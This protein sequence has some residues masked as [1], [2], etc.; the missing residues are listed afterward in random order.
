MTTILT[1]TP[2][3]KLIESELLHSKL[4]GYIIKD[5]SYVSGVGLFSNALGLTFG[6][7]K[8][9]TCHAIE[10]LD[11]LVVNNVEFPLLDVNDVEKIKGIKTIIVDKKLQVGNMDAIIE[12]ARTQLNLEEL[13]FTSESKEPTAL[14]LAFQL[15]DVE[16]EHKAVK[17]QSEFGVVRAMPS[18][19]VKKA[20][21]RPVLK[22]TAPCTELDVSLIGKN[23]TRE[24]VKLLPS[25]KPFYII[26]DRDRKVVGV[27]GISLACALL[28]PRY[29]Y[30]ELEGKFKRYSM[31]E[32]SQV[33]G[34]IPMENLHEFVYSVMFAV[35]SNGRFTARVEAVLTNIT[36]NFVYYSKMNVDNTEI[37]VT[38]IT[39]MDDA[40]KEFMALKDPAND[41]TEIVN[42][43]T[44]TI[45]QLTERKNAI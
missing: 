27:D 45:E 30:A 16:A 43:L 25:M 37:V 6:Q 32:E 44:T 3:K 41:R 38:S 35:R 5:K 14:E 18:D 10:Y 22:S 42:I 17:P 40:I 11:L 9:F 4:V 26:V 15:A 33:T 2:K 36:E 7:A 13:V 24:H 31:G 23:N 20:K 8:S 19:V 1:D 34:L 29:R 28:S 39:C 12:T 21:A